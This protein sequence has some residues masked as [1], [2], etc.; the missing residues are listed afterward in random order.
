MSAS[1]SRRLYL[2]KYVHP[3]KIKKSNQSYK[4]SYS[5]QRIFY[6]ILV[7]TIYPQG[8]SKEITNDTPLKTLYYIMEGYSID[9]T[10]LILEYMTKVCNLP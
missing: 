2:E 9:F 7:R 3:F 8:S 6:Y 4:A 1:K 5:N 10:E